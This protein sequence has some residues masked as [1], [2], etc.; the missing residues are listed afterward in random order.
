MRH[1]R[2]SRPAARPGCRGGGVATGRRAG[3]RSRVP[4]V[5]ARQLRELRPA[6]P[7]SVAPLRQ[8]AVRFAREHGASAAKRDDIALAVSEAVT[9]GVLQGYVGHA[10]AGTIELRA[11]HSR[12]KL[13]IVVCDRGNGLQ[14]RLDGH[15]M[16]LGLALIER[17]S[18]LLE[19]GDTRPGL[20]VRMT[21]ALA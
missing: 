13:V 12:G 21:F 7:E 15:E 17:V 14:T 8:A 2:L 18:D 5:C 3:T 20:L 6:R 1:S 10:A 19:I 9:S 11:T 4:S 16:G